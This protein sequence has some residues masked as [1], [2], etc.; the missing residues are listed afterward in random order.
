MSP[1]SL[2]DDWRAAVAV[3]AMPDISQSAKAAYLKLLDHRN[4][5]TGR[6]NP[7]YQTLADGIAVSK[8]KAMAAVS[9]LE[10]K[11]LLAKATLGGGDSRAPHGGV[12]NS[13][14][15]FYPKGGEK[16]DTAP[17]EENDTGGGENISI[18]GDAGHRAVRGE[19]SDIAP[20]EK[21]D[22]QNSERE[23]AKKN[24]RKGN[25]NIGLA[26]DGVAGSFGSG[27]DQDAADATFEDFWKAY[28]RRVS[29]G[30]AEKAWGAALKKADA[31]TIINGARRYAGA[32]VATEPRYVKHPATWLNDKGWLD[33]IEVRR[34]LIIDSD[35]NEITTG[36]ANVGS[37]RLNPSDAMEDIINAVYSVEAPF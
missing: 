5:H 8:R 16:N 30:A 26:A 2:I 20:R 9:E 22:T 18:G 1:I 3:F 4:R 34:P 15:L 37:G 27:Q 10:A 17:S 21:N 19:K 24:Q 23:P 11:G 13:Y 6:C 32:T 33:E 31:E 14:V 28:P 36:R 7:S 25:N 29:K 12:S 35:G